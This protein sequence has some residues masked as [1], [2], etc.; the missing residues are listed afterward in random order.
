MA[1]LSFFK[2]K[3]IIEC[4]IELLKEL[5]T[6]SQ[7]SGLNL[8]N[9]KWQ[10]CGIS[11]LEGPLSGLRQFLANENPLKTPYFTL[12]ALFFVKVM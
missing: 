6:Y 3:V 2:R 1:A 8:D 5:N 11:I 9:A 10:V 7:F 12:K 4:V